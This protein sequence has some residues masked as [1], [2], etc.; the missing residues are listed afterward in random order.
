MQRAN[1]W[2]FDFV[3]S[4]SLFLCNFLVIAWLNFGFTAIVSTRYPRHLACNRTKKDPSKDLLHTIGVH[5]ARML[6]SPP[7]AWPGEFDAK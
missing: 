6:R 2:I 4:R 5:G 3:F 1:L 7:N